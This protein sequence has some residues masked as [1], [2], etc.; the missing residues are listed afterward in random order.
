VFDGPL[1]AE[2]FQNAPAEADARTTV[3]ATHHRTGFMTA[4]RPT[5]PPTTGNSALA[6]GSDAGAPGDH[7]APA[8]LDD[9]ERDMLNR[10]R[11]D[12]A[13]AVDGEPALGDSPAVAEVANDDAPRRPAI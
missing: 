9:Q 1:P 10:L 12:D 3:P 7:L 13:P 5:E 4:A 11:A 2:P 8:P 6:T